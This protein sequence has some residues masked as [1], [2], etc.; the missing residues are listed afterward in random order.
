M[1]GT[2]SYKIMCFTWNAAGLKM[3]ETSNEVEAK[4][5]RGGFLN[6]MGVSKSC[7]SPNFFEEIRS[8]IL[9]ENPKIVVITT[10]DEDDS[11]T[12]F[13]SDYLPSQ[14]Q[15]INYSL[16]KRDKLDGVGEPASKNP[17]K[18]LKTVG[19]DNPSKTA[20]RV[21]IYVLS[22][23]INQMEIDEK[24][25]SPSFMQ[26]KGQSEERF[27]TDGRTIGTIASYIKH[28]N[29]KFLFISTHIPSGVESLNVKD[30]SS[31][32]RYRNIVIA[33]NRIVF[34]KIFS[35]VVDKIPNE[36]KPNHIFI[37]GDLN[38][39]IH[40]DDPSS[41]IRRLISTT[42]YKTF[43]AKDE[44]KEEIEQKGSALNGFKEG[45]DGNP[46]PLFLPTWNLNRN[47]HNC[48]SKIS[49]DKDN[50]DNKDNK[51]NEGCF[52]KPDNHHFLSIGWHD[53]IIYKNKDESAKKATCTFY[54]RLDYK[55]MDKS[56][57]A[58]VMGIF[59]ITP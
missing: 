48:E 18:D 11:K 37:L 29:N 20:M 21:S 13:H 36:Y 2:N 19:L 34:H 8:K 33:G 57:H 24:E 26:N 59:E 17:Y 40:D 10:Q 50:K 27:I 39:D 51:N 32:N 45:V 35:E 31:Y 4:K 38:Y 52:H 5:A 44:L 49:N 15:G 54:K 3:C 46:G 14:M 9:Q 55:N 28:G 41:L 22:E 47:R 53:R 56:T 1:S 12:Y 43:Y 6:W 23:L 42:D 58:G 30:V 7:I 25:I 16:F